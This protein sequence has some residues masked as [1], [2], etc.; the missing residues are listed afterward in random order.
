M[1][2]GDIVKM[3]LVVYAV[4]RTIATMSAQCHNTPINIGRVLRLFARNCPE[5]SKGQVLSKVGA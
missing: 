1:I 3:A 5:I 2:E 4:A